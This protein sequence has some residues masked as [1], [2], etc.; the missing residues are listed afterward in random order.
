VTVAPPVSRT[1]LDAG[2]LIPAVLATG[3]NSDLPGDLVAQVT[4]VADPPDP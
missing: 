1:Q 3:I 4:S 2:S